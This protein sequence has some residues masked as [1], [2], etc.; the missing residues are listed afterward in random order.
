LHTNYEPTLDRLRGK[1]TPLAIT[2][3]AWERHGELDARSCGWHYVEGLSATND[4]SVAVAWD[5]S[6]GLGHQ[7]QRIRKFGREVIYADG[8]LVSKLVTDWPAFAT[9]QREKL[10]RLMASRSTND[11]AIRWSDEE[12]L[13]TNVFPALNWSGKE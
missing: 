11:P 12:T 7:G 5:K 2:R 10:A 6:W 13:G 1:N 4:A 9:D 8:R 3:A